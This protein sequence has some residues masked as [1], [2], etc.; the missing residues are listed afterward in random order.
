[1]SDADARIY[2]KGVKEFM[3]FKDKRDAID[4]M[5]HMFLL[6]SDPKNNEVQ[7]KKN[8]R[9]DLMQFQQHVAIKSKDCFQGGDEDQSERI[10]VETKLL[11]ILKG[12]KFTKEEKEQ[13]L[14]LYYATYGMEGKKSSIMRGCEVCDRDFNTSCIFLMGQLD[15]ILGADFAQAAPPDPSRMTLYANAMKHV[16]AQIPEHEDYREAKKAVKSSPVPTVKVNGEEMID[17]T[18]L[19]AVHKIMWPPMKK[20]VELDWIQQ[21]TFFNSWRPRLYDVCDKILQGKMDEIECP[22]TAG[23]NA[24]PKHRRG[25]SMGQGGWGNS[26][27]G[28]SNKVT[29]ESTAPGLIVFVIGG[30]CHEEIQVIYELLNKHK[31]DVYL[32]ST[33]MSNP[34]FFVQKG[35]KGMSAGGGYGS[36]GASGPGASGYNSTQHQPQPSVVDTNPF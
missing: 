16:T 30:I 27:R 22:F 15:K 9:E 6:T 17:Y 26:L 14:L 3:P 8:R 19:A 28:G 4:N 21:C 7:Q 11:N 31:K 34:E 29:S 10:S 18:G 20:E 12:P 5:T 1:M 35:L 13:N 24:A 32:G 36:F 25:A 33:H 2:K 23:Q